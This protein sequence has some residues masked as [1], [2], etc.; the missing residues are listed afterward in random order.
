VGRSVRLGGLVSRVGVS[1]LARRLG[2]I[3]RSDDERRVR[4]AENLVRNARRVVATLGE[5]KGAAMKVGQMLSLQE[6]LLPPEVSEVLAALQQQAPKVPAEV[7][8][9][10]VEGALGDVDTH[11]AHLDHEAFAAASIGQVHRGRLH[12]GREVAVKIQYP[13][14]DQIVRA[15]LKSLKHLVG[16]L[17][18]MVSDVDF[19]PI[20]A[21]VRDRLVEELDYAVE[22]NTM[23]EMANL[24]GDIAA[25]VIPEVVPELTTSTVL[26]MTYEPAMGAA[27]ACSEAFDQA[28]RDRWGAELFE[29]LLR[30]LLDHGVLHADPNLANFGFREDGSLVVYDFGCVKRLPRGLVRGYARLFSVVSTGQWGDVPDI[31]HDMGVRRRDGTPIAAD[32]TDPYAEILSRVVDPERPY[33]FGDD[34]MPRELMEIG[35]DQIPETTDLDFPSDII[36]VNRTFGGHLGNLGRLRATADW[37]EMILRYSERAL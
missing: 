12:D 33:T 29:F 27:E 15:D 19:E 8:R 34:D 37:R 25:I 1:L 26:T 14:I 22:A 31:L 5:M 32:L 13:L 36:F 17:V 7:M 9:Y 24:H 10:E 20:W 18:A 16:S 35:I 23:R 2:D 11:F 28:C 6:G 4:E 30:G 21:E 3:G